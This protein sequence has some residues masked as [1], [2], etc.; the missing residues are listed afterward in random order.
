MKNGSRRG[1]LLA[2]F[3]AIGFSVSVSSSTNVAFF[4]AR[5]IVLARVLGPGDFGLA[6]IILTV[7]AAIDVLSD[8]GW[9]RFLIRA[10]DSEHPRAHAQAVVHLL[11]L[12]L[13]LAMAA[14]IALAAF[15]LAATLD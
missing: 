8:L 12:M 7:A 13:G 14:V 11:R 1:G 5:N 15:P 10:Q 2:K 3:G 6:V 4:F 9:D